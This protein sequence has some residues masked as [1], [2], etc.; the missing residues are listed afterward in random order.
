MPPSSL[1]RHLESEALRL[2]LQGRSYFDIV[3]TLIKTAE[4]M[5]I[6]EIDGMTLA[7]IDIEDYETEARRHLALINEEIP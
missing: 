5:M 3:D 1:R 2:W 7:D 6:G 4:A